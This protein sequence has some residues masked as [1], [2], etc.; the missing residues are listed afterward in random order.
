[1]YSAFAPADACCAVFHYRFVYEKGDSTFILADGWP[2]SG[3]GAD[4]RQVGGFA[5]HSFSVCSLS[6]Y[7]FCVNNSCSLLYG[8]FSASVASWQE[9]RCA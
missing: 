7:S 5:A 3:I 9:L 2:Y 6:F 4:L 8:F 1:M